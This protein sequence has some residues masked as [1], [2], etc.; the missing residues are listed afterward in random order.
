[1]GMDIKR[2]FM[3]DLNSSGIYEIRNIVNGKR[4][5][6]SAVNF[7]NRFRSHL[8]SLKRATHH[9]VLLQRSFEKYGADSFV[10]VPLFECQKEHLLEC[11]QMVIDAANPEYNICRVAGSGLGMKHSEETKARMRGRKM[12]EESKAKMRGRKLSDETK[13]KMSEWKR[14]DEIKEKIRNTLLGRKHTEET[15]AKMRG[16]KVSEET[17]AKLRGVNLGRKMSPETKAKMR[18]SHVGKKKT[19]EAIAKRLATMAANKAK[20]LQ[21]D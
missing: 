17:S 13:A 5:V 15:K 9:S 10:F 18:E 12:S 21:L 7:R 11:E 3:I 2:D 6:G 4:Y 19:P 16:R 1:M 20:K 14:S 8:N